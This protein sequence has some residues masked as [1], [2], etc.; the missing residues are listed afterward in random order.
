M[1]TNIVVITNKIRD[2]I[3]DNYK[4]FSDVFEYYGY[5]K[6]FT[7]TEAN[8]SSST[9]KVYKNDVL[10]TSGYTYDSTAIKITITA[11]LTTGDNIRIDYSAYE[12]YSD[13]E[14]TAFIRSALIYIS[15]NKYA[16]FRDRCGKIFPTPTQGE[17]NMIALIAATLINKSISE[18]RT[19]EVT[20]KFNDKQSIDEKIES[21]VNKFS[22]YYGV[23]DFNR[24]EYLDDGDNY[25]A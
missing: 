19:P 12:K 7:L 9:I 16:D 22:S 23:F 21:I 8:V 24:L 5:S 11:S 2:I 1:D 10:I 3:Q 20:I 18:Y 4:T 14:L 25:E 6:E 13:T 15:T 17:E